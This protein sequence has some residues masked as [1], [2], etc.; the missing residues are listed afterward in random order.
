MQFKKTILRAN[1]FGLILAFCLSVLAI[2][3]DEFKPLQTW[4]Q[5]I[6]LTFFS[7]PASEDIVIIAIDEQSLNQLGRWPWPRS[8]HAELINKLTKADVK[9]AGI[10]ILFL[11]PDLKNPLEDKKLAQAIRRNGRIVLPVLLEKTGSSSDLHLFLPL[12]ELAAAAAQLG[13]VNIDVGTGGIVHGINSEAF[14]DSIHIPALP[15]ALLNTG[16]TDLQHHVN[17]LNSVPERGDMKF[18]D[19]RIIMS[20]SDYANSH[21]KQI[22]YIDVL[23]NENAGSTLSGKYVL[24]G[25]TAAGLGQKFATPAS[26][27]STLMTG[28][29]LNANVLNAS[30]SG[31]LL[32]PLDPLWRIL[33]TFFLVFSP[34]AIYCLLSPRQ[35]FL[36]TILFFAITCGVCGVLVEVF[37]VWY[38]PSSVLLA[39]LLSYPLCSWHRQE[40]FAHSLFKE[41]GKANATLLAIGD[42]V[43]STDAN[44]IIE[45]MNPVAENMASCSLEQAKGQKLDMIFTIKDDETLSNFF[46]IT[47]L[48]KNGGIFK[49]KAP[50][51]LINRNNEEFA[52]R[53]A[54]NPITGVSGDLA[55]MVFAFTDITE[56]VGISQRMTF[57]ANHDSL[58]KLPNRVLLQDRLIKAIDTANRFNTLVAVLFVD[59][60][61]FKKINDGMGHAVGDLLLREVALRLRSAKRQSDTAARWGGDEFVILLESLA[62]EEV[63]IEIA[64]KILIKLSQSYFFE[65]QELFVTPSI[66]ISMYPKDGLTADVLLTRADAAMYRVKEAGRNN[67]CFYSQGLND[68]AKERLELEKEM[69]HAILEEG[70]EVYYQPLIELSSGRIVGVEALLRWHHQENGIMLP[71]EFLPLAEEVGLIIPIG[72]WLIHTVCSQLQAWQ[73]ADFPDLYAAINLSPRQVLQKNLVSTIARALKNRQI[74]NHCLQIEITEQTMIKDVDRIANVLQE[75]KSLG[76]SVAIDDFGMGYSSL[77]FLKRF[78]ID[79]LKI[80]KSFIADVFTNPDDASIVQSV[81]SLGHNMH[82]KIVAEGIETQSHLYFL[83][84]RNCDIGQGFYFSQPLGAKEMT[85]F[86]QNGLHAESPPPLIQHRS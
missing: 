3:A 66:G 49:R 65:G 74:S 60:D 52:I 75:L 72:E 25:M 81:I 5:V 4:N 17:N 19:Y 9:A 15:L 34:I 20:F 70:F 79:M 23:N 7:K 67:F 58:T 16:K 40:L 1:Y 28:I 71:D 13:H 82:M 18:H 37:S 11:E 21:F 48:L 68:L 30:L 86:L 85:K 39:L 61:S 35:A 56:I 59:L 45:F 80:D 14:N 62:H 84:E 10:D 41:K 77:N 26:K 24:V 53:L 27:N 73:K 69:H 32:R 2:V 33:L 38:G 76:I 51:F 64:N 57:L 29:E 54:A 63:V 44:G 46:A 55:G 42:A 83:K 8:V 22:S 31:L 47:R 78:P 12:S 50:Q 6:G 43:V 36:L